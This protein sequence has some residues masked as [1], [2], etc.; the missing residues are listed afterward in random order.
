MKSSS[1]HALVIDRHLGELS[2]EAVELLEAYL[3]GNAAA[4]AETERIVASLTA[5]RDAVLRHPELV[6]RLEAMPAAVT[7]AQPRHR[8]AWI[9]SWMAR[10]AAV[11]LPAALTGAAGFMAGR[12][13]GPAPTLAVVAPSS[14]SSSSA[15]PRKESP[16]AR[17]RMTFDPAGEGLQ[18]VRV[19]TA[20]SKFIP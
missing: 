1:L 4:Q 11:L 8:T 7:T 3:A 14:S 12:S 19:E 18:V 17:Y 9:H 5:T 13:E 6:A 15:Q 2:P 16:W 10:A 20:S